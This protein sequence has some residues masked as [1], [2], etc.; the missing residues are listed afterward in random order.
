MAQYQGSTIPFILSLIG[1]IV[2]LLTGI[3]GLA[4]F[5]SGGPSWSGFGGWMSGMMSGYHG[6]MG[7]GQYGYF[8][9]L[10]VLGLISGVII[11]ICSVLLWAHPQDHIIWGAVILVF[12]VVSVVDMGGYFVGAILGLAGGALAISYRPRK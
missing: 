7:G 12:S 9:F 3:I 1:G 5:G 2:I 10:S 11:V 4:W 8:G 6:F